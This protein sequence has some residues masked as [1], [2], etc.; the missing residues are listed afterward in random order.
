VQFTPRLRQLLLLLSSD[1]PGEVVAAAA[2][3][4]RTLKSEGHDFHD[5]VAG[6][7]APPLAPK[8]QSE[9]CNDGARRG[10]RDFCLKHQNRLTVR[11]L[12][13]VTSIGRWRG[14]LTDKQFN[15]LS[16]IHARLSA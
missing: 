10:M 11:E 16:A 9:D 12:E 2:A 7:T 4:K 13:F 6:L 1:Q 8:F 5:L 3:I 15:W 14:S